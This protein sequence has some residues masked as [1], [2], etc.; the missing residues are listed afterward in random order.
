MI[1]LLFE[2]Y[3]KQLVLRGIAAFTPICPVSVHKQR[4]KTI[5]YLFGA[6]NEMSYDLGFLKSLGIFWQPGF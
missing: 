6:S 2:Q 4:S 1:T 3:L 5:T